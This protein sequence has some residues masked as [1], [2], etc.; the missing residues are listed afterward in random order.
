MRPSRL[1]KPLLA[2][3]ALLACALLLGACG[4]M[5]IKVPKS[6]PYYTGALLFREHCAGCHSLKEV[7]AEGSATSVAN[8]VRTQAP[9]FNFRKEK[10]ENILYAIRNGGFSGAIMPENIVV[11]EQAEAVARFLEHY[12]GAEAPK[13]PSVSI[14]LSTK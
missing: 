1:L 10:Y 2:A 7:G 13:V 8:R 14:Q 6:S 12:A 5:G 3:A 9:N 11:G 4:T